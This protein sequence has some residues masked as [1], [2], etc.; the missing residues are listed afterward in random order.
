VNG[1]DEKGSQMVHIF[2]SQMDADDFIA[3]SRKQ[4]RSYA[5]RATEGIRDRQPDLYVHGNAV[6]AN[7]Y[8]AAALDAAHFGNLP[9]IDDDADS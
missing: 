8:Y 2:A 5:R 4:A 6:M 3:A 7:L 9:E 1:T